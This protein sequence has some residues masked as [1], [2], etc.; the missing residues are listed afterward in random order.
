[1]LLQME[2]PVEKSSIGNI[3]EFACI[4]LGTTYGCTVTENCMNVNHVRLY[5]KKSREYLLGG[6]QDYF[7]V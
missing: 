3:F 2:P 4:P 7:C 1:M 5:I 6:C